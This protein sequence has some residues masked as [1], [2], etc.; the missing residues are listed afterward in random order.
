MLES[1]ITIINDQHI[2]SGTFTQTYR[3]FRNLKRHGIE[4]EFYQFLID[5]SVS[6]LPEGLKLKKGYLS[7]L[8][9]NHKSFYDLKLAINFLS[10]RNW[11]TFRK[12]S[13]DV[14]LLSYPSLLPL[15]R[16]FRKT[17]AEG[18]DLYFMYDGNEAGTLGAYTRRTYKHYKEAGHIVANSEFTK[19]EFIRLLDISPEKISVVYRAVGDIFCPGK[20]D[21]RSKLGIDESSV[22]LLSVG[23]DNPNKNIETIVRLIKEL[24]QNYILIRV[25]RNFRTEKLIKKLGLGN[26]IIALGNVEEMFLSDLYRCSDIFLFPSTFEGFGIPVI[27]AMAS[28][29]PVISSNTTSLPEV[30]GNAGLLCDP[31]D[32]NCWKNKIETLVTDKHFYAKMRDKGIERSKYFSLDNQFVQLMKVIESV[33]GR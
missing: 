4:C 1:E 21:I 29:L 23:G 12:I 27:E 25:G 28:G 20:C 24:P 7:T 9:W 16:Y 5:S 2:F 10:G 15:T 11:K 8:N 30:V 32:L 6:Y 18:H 13:A 33:S 3:I 31:Y 17:I 19:N 14:V 26:R 22:I